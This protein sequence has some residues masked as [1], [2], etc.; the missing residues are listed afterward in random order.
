MDTTFLKQILPGS[1]KSK[2]YTVNFI[3]ALKKACLQ[4]KRNDIA[5]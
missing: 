5:F 4:H 3:S 1:I 2:G